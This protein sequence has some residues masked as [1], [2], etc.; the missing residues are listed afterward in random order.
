MTQYQPTLYDRVLDWFSA[1]RMAIAKVVVL[2]AVA[3]MVGGIV[4]GALIGVAA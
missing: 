4:I 2:V 1:N 3:A